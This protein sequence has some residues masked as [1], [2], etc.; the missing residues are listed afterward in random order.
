MREALVNIGDLKVGD[1]I[2]RESIDNPFDFQMVTK[3]DQDSKNSVFY[4]YIND[5][6]LY[7]TIQN[8]DLV[9]IRID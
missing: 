5:S 3:I 1:I 2:L 6:S 4:V 7:Y 9:K 8:G